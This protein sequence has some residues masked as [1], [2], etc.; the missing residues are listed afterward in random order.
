MRLSEFVCDE[1]GEPKRGEIARLVRITGIS[2]PTVHAVARGSDY[3]RSYD[4]AR[5][6]S[7]ATDGVVTVA[8][9]C[10][11]DPRRHVAKPKR[12][13]R[14]SATKARAKR[15]DRAQAAA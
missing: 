2:Y 4:R 3:L 7:D 5:K 6:L 11:P 14:K 12:T 1:N 13:R 8:D 10:T 9:L 15:R